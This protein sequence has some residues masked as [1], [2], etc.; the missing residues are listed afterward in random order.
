MS[1]V[2]FGGASFSCMN[3]GEDHPPLPVIFKEIEFDNCTFEGGSFAGV[4]LQGANISGM[5]ID[6]IPVSEMIE[7]YR[8]SRQAA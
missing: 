8:A 4:R 6:S 2:D 1:A 3:T 5:T 7:A